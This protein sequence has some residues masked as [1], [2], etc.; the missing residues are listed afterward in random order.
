MRSLA[1]CAL[2]LRDYATANSYYR[3]AASEFKG[4]KSWRNYAAARRWRPCRSS[5]RRRRAK[6]LTRRSTRRPPISSSRRCRATRRARPSCSSPCRKRRSRGRRRR[7]RAIRPT[8]PSRWSRSRRR[9]ATCAQRSSSSSPP[10]YLA[11]RPR[12]AQ[13]RLP[14]HP[15]WLRFI[16]CSQRRH[17]VRAY[18]AALKVYAHRGWTHIED[19]IHF[20][21]GRNCARSARSNLRSPSSSACSATRA[22][23]RSASK[24]S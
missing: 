18:N 15:R 7:R 4:D 12:M 13:V 24:L 5:L 14:P 22:S 1:D 20:T 3:M 17:A 23:R 19:H 10:S 11:P 9:R 21:L 6:R 2:I 8:P 16:Q